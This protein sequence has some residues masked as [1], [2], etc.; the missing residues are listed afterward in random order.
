M[1]VVQHWF[2]EV[3]QWITDAYSAFTHY[4]FSNLAFSNLFMVQTHMGG[5]VSFK[6]TN[7]SFLNNIIH[8]VIHF[9]N[10]YLCLGL[11]FDYFIG[12]KADGG[13]PLGCGVVQVTR[14]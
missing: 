7:P 4:V 11:W 1:K 8:T 12:V 2:N 14:E 5:L 6:D 9:F 13:N 3:F 10:S